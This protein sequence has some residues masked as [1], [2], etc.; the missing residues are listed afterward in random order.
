MKFKLMP[1]FCNILVFTYTIDIDTKTLHRSE[2]S[3]RCTIGIT[4]QTTSRYLRVLFI[5]ASPYKSITPIFLIF[6]KEK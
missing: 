2:E 1:A 4:K 3:T 5:L 6:A